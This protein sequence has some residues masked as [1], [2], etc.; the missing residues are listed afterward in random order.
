VLSYK[1][2]TVTLLLL[3]DC[4]VYL[5]II[6]TV[7]CELRDKCQPVRTGADEATVLGAVSRG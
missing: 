3:S 1:Q 5:K 6:H 7:T 2:F 4:G